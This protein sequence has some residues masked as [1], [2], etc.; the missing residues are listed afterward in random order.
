VRNVSLWR[1]VLGIEKSVIESVEFD[2]TAQVLV[3]AVRPTS[4]Q[5]RRCG[6]CRRRCPGFDL[7]A[8]R[9]RWRGLD[10]GTIQVRLEAESPRVWCREHGV[11]VAH[12]PWAKHGAGHTHAFDDQVAW[13]AVRASKTTVSALMRVAWRT[14]GSIITRVAEDAM[15]GVDR[16]EGLRRIGIDE[17]SY[18]RGHKYLTVVVDHD[19]RRLLWAASGRDR[20]TLRGF[21]DELG[22]ERSAQITHISADA[23]DWVAEV[24]AERC[25]QAVQCADPFHV[26]QWATE[27][28]DEIRRET[29]N[30]ARREAAATRRA[31]PGHRRARGS[32]D[33]QRS[34]VRSRWALWK[35]PENLTDQQQAKLAWIAKTE[36][37][38]HRAYLLKE[39]LRHVFKFRGEAG[40]EALDRW[41]GWARRSRIP[42][43]VKLARRITK[44]R[45]KIVATLEHGLSNALIESTNTKIRLLT[46]MAFGF[47]GP[48]PL[49]ALAMLAHGGHCPPLPG[50]PQ[51]HTTVR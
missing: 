15:T 42:A 41:C 40:I 20:Q 21:F 43:F 51:T 17:I 34:I 45:A 5:C 46:R 36:P 29:W 8:G 10:L 37:R 31:G 32:L 25:P 35:N 30:A 38:L 26:V 3:A 49:I 4:R 33:K 14:V 1:G 39:G 19:T 50:R 13:L 16:F 28:L 23:A 7:G 44:H 11:V 22:P 2:E 9:R 12:V 6:I 47:H 48:E 24:V 18:K 27:A